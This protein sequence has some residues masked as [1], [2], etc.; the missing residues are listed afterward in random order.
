MRRAMGHEQEAPAGAAGAVGEDARMALL[1]R[2]EA[3]LARGDVV[4][5]TDGFE[6]AAGMRHA[7]DA[8]MGLVRSFMQA[9]EYRRALAF[10]AHVAGAHLD[11]P[12]AA[13][14]YAWLLRADGQDA[15]AQ[16]VLR[17]ALERAP[18]DPVLLAASD[19][20]A[21]AR[22]VAAGLLL[23]A[24]HRVAPQ[25]VMAGGQPPV[26]SGARV[27]S[28]GVLVRGGTQALV[29]AA[30][31]RGAPS[32]LWVRNGLGEGSRALIDR[33]RQPLDPQGVSLLDLEAPLRGPAMDAANLREPFAGSPGFVLAYAESAAAEA[34]W[35]WLTAGFFGPMHGD[36]DA[37]PLG[38][39][40][41]AGRQGG[42]ALDGG[43]RLAGIVL[44]GVDDTPVLLPVSRWKALVSAERAAAPA[45]ALP[46]DAAQQ[47][48][49]I[50]PADK[51]Y[52]DGLRLALQIVASH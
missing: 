3:D 26:E 9:G 17:A 11:A 36:A 5:A 32:K 47:G 48:P 38:I 21:S 50:A 6:R 20:F 2:A 12:E 8:E 45:A 4:R 18:Q 29:P 10:C 28:S 43:G 41:P 42:P 33:T 23:Q 31:L 30:A 40:L 44:A 22:P 7:A 25:A 35:P 39:E 14:L 27:V 1:N 16:R 34:A 15:Y 19:A 52:E 24:P 49:R 51:A 13:A 37:R 46:M